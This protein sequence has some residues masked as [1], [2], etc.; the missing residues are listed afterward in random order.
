MQ[1]I[2]KRFKCCTKMQNSED[3]VRIVFVSDTHS[4]HR[5]HGVLPHGNILIHSGDFTL[6]TPPD[7]E[8]Y[9]DF[10][11]WFS[12][13]SHEHKILIRHDLKIK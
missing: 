7:A 9:K 3:C 13:Q 2:L 5:K 11:D 1:N 10:I 6:T 12:S 4:E 8:E